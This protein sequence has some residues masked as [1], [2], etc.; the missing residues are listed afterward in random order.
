MSRYF[1]DFETTT[2]ELP[3]RVWLWA[4]C[5]DKD[6]KIKYGTTIDSY[7]IYLKCIA[8][9]IKRKESTKVYFFNE[10][11]DGTFLLDYMLKNG[12]KSIDVLY[13]DDTYNSNMLKEYKELDIKTEVEIEELTKTMTQFDKD[14]IKTQNK[15][16]IKR[17]MVIEQTMDRRFST[18][19]TDMGVFYSIKLY[20]VKEWQGQTFLCMVDIKDAIHKLGKAKLEEFGEMVGIKKG[21][22]PIHPSLPLDYKPSKKEY[23]YVKNDVLIVKLAYIMLTEAGLCKDTQASSALY[24]YKQIIGAKKFIKLYPQIP[25]NFN[26]AYRGGFCGVNEIYAGKELTNVYENDVVSMYPSVMEF[27][28]LPYGFPEQIDG[29]IENKKFIY[30]YQGYIEYKFKDKTIPI[31]RDV[32]IHDNL[33]NSHYP[34]EYKG[35]IM[36]TDLDLCIIKESC[37]YTFNCVYSYQFKCMKG[38][39]SEYLKKWRDIK[40]ESEKGSPMYSVAKVMQNSLYG[41][42]GTKE[43]NI[44]KEPFIN[45]DNAISYHNYNGDNKKAVYMPMAI[46]ITA[47]ARF[48]LYKM[49]KVVGFENFVYSDTDSVYTLNPL[50]QKDITTSKELGKWEQEFNEKAVFYCPKTYKCQHGNKVK[51]KAA[52]LPDDC[53][54]NLKYEDFYI[55]KE[56]T[57]KKSKNVPGGK[58]IYDMPFKLDVVYI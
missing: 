53:K 20:L 44:L 31:I 49:I 3:L 7:M 14:V 26:S 43:E 55:G 12:Y 38:L 39:F 33:I 25:F 46:F 45:S 22:T 6:D 2:Q 1:A 41:K 40:N 23:K 34:K 4:S 24:E 54:V 35:D 56:F 21:E 5:S 58:M 13:G 57:V 15:E 28:R 10:K 36:L 32:K 48:K 42:F 27:E 47:Y 11:F 37:D 19:V 18:V 30:I 50:G 29:Y 9:S 8:G 17:K 51:I 52:G 16:K